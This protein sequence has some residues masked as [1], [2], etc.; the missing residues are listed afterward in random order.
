MNF[1]AIYSGI[2]QD[3]QLHWRRVGRYQRQSF[4][5][6]QR[7]IVQRFTASWWSMRP[8]DMQWPCTMHQSHHKPS[9]RC[10][11]ALNVVNSCD[12]CQQP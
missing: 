5:A 2:W 7:T 10:G 1:I 8:T 9:I 3:W 11:K 4:F 12:V 6:Q